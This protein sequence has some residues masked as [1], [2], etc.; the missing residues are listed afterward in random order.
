MGVNALTGFG[1]YL[2]WLDLVRAES[3]VQNL[4]LVFLDHRQRGLDAQIFLHLLIMGEARVAAVSVALPYTVVKSF[5]PQVT[6]V[7]IS[8]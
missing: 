1:N 5:F 7:A 6:F 4:R 2:S 8:R 3:Q